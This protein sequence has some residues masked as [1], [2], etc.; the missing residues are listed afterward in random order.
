MPVGVAKPR[1]NGA[2]SK[3]LK[4]LKGCRILPSHGPMIAGKLSLVV[5]KGLPVSLRALWRGGRAMIKGLIF[6]FDGLILD[7]ETPAFLAWRTVF[8]AH[9]CDLRLEAWADSIGRNPNHF[10][11]CTHLERCLG[12][13]VSGA[14]LR[15]QQAEQEAK[16]IER[17]S[18]LPGVREYLG[19]A[20]K[21]GLKLGIASSSDRGWVMR[22]L[23]RLGLEREFGVVRTADDVT[24]TKP[25]PELYLSALAALELKAAEAIALEDSGHGVLAAK[26]AG[27]FCV[28]IPNPL[29]RELKIDHADLIIHSL[30]DIPLERV[31]E[32]VE[33]RR[34]GGEGAQAE[35]TRVA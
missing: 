19:S 21:L 31:L 20:C 35:P 12:R 24:S 1:T 23:S 29:T 2:V 32:I 13:P 14:S 16:L 4:S 11:P 17:E 25:D 30:A 3:I 7:T 34:R 22:H 9:G 18:I 33:L 15:R 27:L 26:R 5:A 8:A 10:D 28:A 6:D